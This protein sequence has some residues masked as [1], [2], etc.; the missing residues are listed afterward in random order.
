V[1][2]KNSIVPNL[3]PCLLNQSSKQTSRIYCRHRQ[4]WVLRITI[5][6]VTSSYW[7]PTI[8]QAWARHN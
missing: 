6:L 3:L 4:H 8:I 1:T 7:V 2:H 5:K